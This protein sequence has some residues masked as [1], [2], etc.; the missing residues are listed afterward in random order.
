MGLE[1][2]GKSLL[3]RGCRP[4]L[5]RHRIETASGGV[6]TS[7]AEAHPSAANGVPPPSPG[8][9]VVTPPARRT[10]VR[11]DMDFSKLMP[12]VDVVYGAVISYGFVEISQQLLPWFKAPATPLPGVEL[13]LLFFVLNFLAADFVEARL[14]N[15]AFPY[16][17]RGRFTVDLLVALLFFLAFASASASSAV[18]LAAL[19]LI[20]IL[21]GLWGHILGREGRLALQYPR[22]IVVSHVGAGMTCVAGYFSLLLSGNTRISGTI[23]LHIVVLYSFWII[24]VFLLKRNFGIP[25]CEFELFPISAVEFITRKIL[26]LIAHG[27]KGPQPPL[28]VA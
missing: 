14:F 16:I 27:R 11:E 6:M 20:F 1:S 10:V 17:G 8:N 4:A 9:P 2:V 13:G 12:F 28:P 23:L 21:G 3:T 19:G 7:E 5:V 22:L 18:F 25:E 26:Q 24:S 15:N